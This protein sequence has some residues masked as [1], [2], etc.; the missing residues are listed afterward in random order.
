MRRIA[1]RLTYANVVATLALLIAIGTGAAYAAGTVFSADIVNN[2]IR[3]VD[4]R[5]DTSAGG[6]LTGADVADQS[7]VDTCVAA[8]V[9]IGQLCF[10]SENVDRNWN[11]ALDFCAGLDLRVPTVGEA[12]ELAATHDLPNVSQTEDFWTDELVGQ[13]FQEAV[14]V[15][16]AANLSAD[17]P[18]ALKETACVTTPTN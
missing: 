8:T 11:E 9:R 14:T 1:D 6:G 4:V 7:G 3:S 12:V 17:P 18:N 2:Q 10:R 5:D 15:N 13:E 16:D